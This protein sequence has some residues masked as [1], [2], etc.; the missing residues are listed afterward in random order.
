MLLLTTTENG[1]PAPNAFNARKA[2][3]IVINLTST[4]EQDIVYFNNVL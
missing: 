1:F 4:I 3:D 2:N